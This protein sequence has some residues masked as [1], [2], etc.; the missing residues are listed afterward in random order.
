MTAWHDDK[1]LKCV[2]LCAGKGARARGFTLKWRSLFDF[3]S[4]NFYS[5]LMH[6]PKPLFTV[7]KKP[8]LYWVVNYWKRYTNDFIFVVGYKKDEVIK[9]VETLPINATF[10][11]Q[12]KLGGIAHAIAHTKNHVSDKFIVVL[13]DC[14]CK[15]NFNF[16]E[17]MEHGI[18]VWQT[19]NIED[20]KRSYSVEPK[21]GLV[22]RVVEKP[23]EL[24]NNLCGMGFYFFN[25]K[26]FDYIE[27][28]PPSS[29]RNEIEIGD[30]IQNMINS[31]EKISPVFFEGQY[32]NVTYPED[33]GRAEI[34]L[35]KLE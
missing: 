19:N 8:L 27:K 21:D 15:G 29:L 24:P 34:F 18:G 25:K 30:V 10:V 16:P 33:I 28:T 17:M 7:H 9:Y 12:D 5:N 1:N 20:I 2:V 4:I 22:Y 11:E 31:G 6:K 13:G 35:D 23:K 3:K 32:L 26:V 14:L